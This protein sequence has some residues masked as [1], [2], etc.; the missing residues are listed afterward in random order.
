MSD[1]KGRWIIELIEEIE[2][3]LASLE[4]I[5]CPKMPAAVAAVIRGQPSKRQTTKTET[6]ENIQKHTRTALS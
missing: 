3:A 1:I 5:S 4:L 6:V 2:A